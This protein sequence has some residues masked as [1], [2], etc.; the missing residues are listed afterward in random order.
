MAAFQV[1]LLE[2][3]FLVLFGKKNDSLGDLKGY[4]NGLVGVWRVYHVSKC[5]ELTK[6]SFLGVKTVTLSHFVC[7][8]SV[9]QSACVKHIVKI[10]FHFVELELFIFLTLKFVNKSSV[11]LPIMSSVVQDSTE[12]C[13]VKVF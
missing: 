9:L 13:Q 5:Y 8:E 7:Q 1:L 11:G 2:F 4:C 10:T 6:C 3:I 12:N